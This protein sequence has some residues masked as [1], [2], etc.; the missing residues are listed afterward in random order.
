MIDGKEIMTKFLL[1]R[2]YT[3]SGILKNFIDK[4]QQNKLSDK[5]SIKYP[6][7]GSRFKLSMTVS[8]G[9]KMVEFET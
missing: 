8:L 1:N 4:K 6:T 5:D 9:F 2:E 7:Y 3:K